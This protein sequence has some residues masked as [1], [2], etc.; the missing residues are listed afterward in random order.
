MNP[1]VP[2]AF[3]FPLCRT[4]GLLLGGL[5]AL[6]IRGDVKWN[7]AWT[8]PFFA[9]SSLLLLLTA[10]LG[11]SWSN[12]TEPFIRFGYTLVDVFYFS[13]FL[14]LHG[15]DAVA[16]FFR[17]LLSVKFLTLAG[18]YSYGIYVYHFLFVWMV[19]DEN[20]PDIPAFLQLTLLTVGVS[21]LSY[22][23]YE[24]QFLKLKKRFSS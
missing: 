3:M 18:K 17:R 8:Y 19:F 9:F 15:S 12:G 5:A 22:H 20:V 11:H 2:F 24:N 1:N 14:V 21:V 4:E 23:L 6:I 13:I 7:N 10:Y 16:G